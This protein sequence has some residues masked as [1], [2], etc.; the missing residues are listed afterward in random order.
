MFTERFEQV[1]KGGEANSVK[2][3]YV[4][5][6]FVHLPDVLISLS[7]ELDSLSYQTLRNKFTSNM[8]TSTQKATQTSFSKRDGIQRASAE[9]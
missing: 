7:S 8:Y 1:E 5:L 6:S 4:L 2:M 3:F 9:L